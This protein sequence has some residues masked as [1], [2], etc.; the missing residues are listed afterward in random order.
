MLLGS[1]RGPNLIL[2]L[3]PLLALGML[4]CTG[5]IQTRVELAHGL[6]V[7]ELAVWSSAVGTVS[8]Q[9]HGRVLERA[10]RVRAIREELAVLLS[11][12]YNLLSGGWVF[13][14][15]LSVLTCSAE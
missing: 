5:R 8:T 7:S 15:A 6:N 1:T 12:K 4:E 2:K 14:G 3:P 9:W 10:V 11:L 13:A